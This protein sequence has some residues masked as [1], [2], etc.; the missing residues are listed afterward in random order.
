VTEGVPTGP[1]PRGLVPASDARAAIGGAPAPLLRA[2]DGTFL[3]RALARLRDAGVQ[4]IVVSVRDPRGPVAAAARRAGAELLVVTAS[5]PD[6][7]GSLRAATLEEDGE[8]TPWLVLPPGFPLLLPATLTLI[9]EGWAKAPPDVRL[10]APA[11]APSTPWR[12][13]APLLVHGAPGVA[14]LEAAWAGR[15]PEEALVLRVPVEDPGATTLV[16]TLPVYR[17][18]FPGVY[19]KR[20]QKW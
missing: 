2:E 1:M 3:E 6:P 16:D 15:E 14:V 12:S 13:L 20:F 11:S 19:R 8:A 4:D 10:V 5:E 9:L 17:R 7:L 18:H